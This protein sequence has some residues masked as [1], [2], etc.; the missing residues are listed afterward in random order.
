MLNKSEIG[1]KSRAAGKRF[2]VKVKE[3][4]EELGYIVFRNTNDFDIAQSKFVQA[5]TKWNPY[6]RRPMS[7]STG[8]PDFLLID[9]ATLTPI[10]VECKMSKYLDNTEKIKAY[11][12][13]AT[14][15]IQ[16]LV[17]Y[18]DK[19]LIKAYAI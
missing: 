13:K 5:K 17:C 19:S 6:T 11:T 2:E 18:K 10:F 8:F 16:V 4:L 7:I 9:K 1:K 12:I 15:K 14:Y 3:H